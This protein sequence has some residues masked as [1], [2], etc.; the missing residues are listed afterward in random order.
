[1]YITH[2]KHKT[3]KIKQQITHTHTEAQ[4]RELGIGTGAKQTW[5]LDSLGK[6]RDETQGDA[7]G[8]RKG[9]N[10]RTG[11]Q[12]YSWRQNTDRPDRYGT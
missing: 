10:N 4:T 5:R 2:I 11:Q 12:T 8:N 7:H 6:Q 3:I 1:M 9:E